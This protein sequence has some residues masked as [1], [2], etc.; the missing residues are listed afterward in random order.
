MK[1]VTV[2]LSLLLL[3]SN[4]ATAKM[5]ACPAEAVVGKVSWIRPVPKANVVRFGLFGTPRAITAT[6]TFEY[7]VGPRTN[8]VI[9][10]ASLDLLRES[11]TKGLTVSIETASD[12][13]G[14]VLFAGQSATVRSIGVYTSPPSVVE[15][16]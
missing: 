7:P 16:Q 12:T 11:L 3:A 4:T 2:I 1:M 13:A 14:C 8:Q 5:N 9:V 10:N 6:K 15:P